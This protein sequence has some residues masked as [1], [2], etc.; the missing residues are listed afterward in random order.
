[1]YCEQQ[2]QELNYSS[3]SSLNDLPGSSP[4]LDSFDSLTQLNN[5]DDLMIVKK[6]N[7]AKFPVFL[8]FSPSRGQYFAMK[9]FPHTKNGI[10]PFF[11]NEARFEPLQHNNIISIVHTET[12][13]QAVF[14]ENINKVSYTL[15]ELA[16]FGD[17]FDLIMTQKIPFD[18]TL[19]RTYFHQ[20]IEGIEYM[21]SYGVSHLDLKLENLLVGNN[22][23]LK[24]G[25]F[26]Q[27]YIQNQGHVV[28]KGTVCYRAPELIRGNCQKPEA[29]DI[30]SAGII[31]FL[32]K[33]G[34]VLPHSERQK[35]K[36]IDLFALMLTNPRTFW[37]KHCEIQNKSLSFF[38]KDFINLFNAMVAADPE[39]RPSISQIKNSK[40][41]KGPIY[42][43]EE[44]LLYMS[45][46]FASN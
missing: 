12:E 33:S 17:F 2:E 26:D 16:P 19:C 32:F 45:K 6:L 37:E 8:T 41:Y 39:Q 14:E 34:G 13:K 3:A 23:V 46:F 25:D 7:Q 44:V 1:M 9:V 24:I 35:Y 28:T 10:S 40:W 20:L 11:A 42:T 4:S 43:Q 30:F 21:H 36:N 15:M 27:A 22:F 29:A 31:L 18:E 38:G 5:F